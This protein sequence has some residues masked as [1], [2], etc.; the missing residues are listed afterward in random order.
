MA[1]HITGGELSYKFLSGSGSDNRY[2][3]T[4]KL[5]RDCFSNGAQLDLTAFITVYKKNAS[6]RGELFKTYEV[7]ISTRNTLS[8]KDP[9]K[10]IDNPPRVCYEV[11]IY[12]IEVGLP[13]EAYG[14]SIAY[15]RCCRIE[16]I[17]NVSGSGQVGQHTVLMCQVPI[18]L[19]RHL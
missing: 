11:G 10:C 16:N 2:Q 13:A 6:G 9:G 5:Y 15:Q 18:Y 7:P 17:S 4:L 1:R 14:Y 3:I 19:C 12:T 8:L